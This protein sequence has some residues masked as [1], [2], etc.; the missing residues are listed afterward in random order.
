MLKESMINCSEGNSVRKNMWF[1][2][3]GDFRLK[4]VSLELVKH[5]FRTE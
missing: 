4:L 5:L 2:N 1:S 3:M